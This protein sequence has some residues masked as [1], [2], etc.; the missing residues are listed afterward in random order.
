LSARRKD[1]NGARLG[2]ERSDT[3]RGQ[4]QSQNH[5]HEVMAINLRQ[6]EQKSCKVALVSLRDCHSA[7]EPVTFLSR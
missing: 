6:R 5:H 4:R 1:L 2:V 3:N 7:V